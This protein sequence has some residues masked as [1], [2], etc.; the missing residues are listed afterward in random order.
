MQL[1]VRLTDAAARA[2]QSFDA[3]WQLARIDYWLG[4]HGPE[5]D[6]RNYLEQG[7]VAAQEAARLQPE[8]PEGH[9]WTAAN[10]GAVAENFGIRA[11]LKYRKAIRQA[12]ETVL[13]LD[14]SYMEGSANRA[15]GRYF[16]KVPGW[17]GG[18]RTR[19]EEHLRTSLSYNPDSTISHFFLAELFM[20]AG[21][22]ADARAELHRVSTAP[23]SVE[24]APEDR[25]F[26]RRAAALLE[27]LDR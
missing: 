20:D 15:L 24:W 1:A 18:S 22:V 9:F 21:R 16:H 19:A 26:K 11:G 2:R 8:R 17:L 4:A 23:L 6:R 7:I 5:K 14:P 13:R 25:D 3:R 27:T 12:L 10:M